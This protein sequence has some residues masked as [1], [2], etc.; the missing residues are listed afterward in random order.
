MVNGYY[1]N[2]EY[3]GTWNWEPYV[4]AGIRKKKISL[5]ENVKILLS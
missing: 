5:L 4:F 3:E 2:K 1:N